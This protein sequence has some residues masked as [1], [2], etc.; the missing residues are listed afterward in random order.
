MLTTALVLIAV[1]FHH[2]LWEQY[3]AWTIA[4]TIVAGALQICFWPMWMYA[5]S[6]EPLIKRWTREAKKRSL[7][8]EPDI[9]QTYRLRDLDAGERRELFANLDSTE[10]AVCRNAVQL[11]VNLGDA[12]VGRIDCWPVK[13]CTELQL[14]AT[15]CVLR[16]WVYFLREDTHFSEAVLVNLMFPRVE[17]EQ[18]P[19]RPRVR[20]I[21]EWNAPA[22]AP[23]PPHP[24]AP[25]PSLIGKALDQLNETVKNAILDRNYV[26]EENE[27]GDA[28]EDVILAPLDRQRFAEGMQ[29]KFSEVLEHV[30]DTV[31]AAKTDFELAKSEDQVGCFLHEM[32]W[33]ALCLALDLRDP[34][35]DLAASSSGATTKQPIPLGPHSAETW[36]KK[37]R[38]MRALGM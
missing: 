7:R 3:L 34:Q 27:F 21:A 31:A 18:E 4:A 32:R 33:D 16:E 10:D 37:Y 30:A 19:W 6:L 13:R 25:E 36:A 29:A 17:P 15:L 5:D 28:E 9:E 8:N 12:P 24:R 23:P 26:D 38:R 20:M 11:L 22:P 1:A 14:T 35:S 2:A